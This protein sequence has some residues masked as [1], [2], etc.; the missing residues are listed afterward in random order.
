MDEKTRAIQYHLLKGMEGS[1][2]QYQ[3]NGGLHKY[4]IEGNHPN[5]WLYVAEELVDDSSPVILINIINI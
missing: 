3:H 5:H 2:I 4:R 1:Q